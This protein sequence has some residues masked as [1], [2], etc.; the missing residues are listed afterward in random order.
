MSICVRTLQ[1]ISPN[2]C[3][4]SRFILP[5]FN[6]IFDI[7][8]LDAVSTYILALQTYANELSRVRRG[9]KARLHQLTAWLR[10]KTGSSVWICLRCSVK[11][12]SNKGIQFIVRNVIK[13]FSNGHVTLPSGLPNARGSRFRMGPNSDI[14]PRNSA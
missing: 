8:I 5:R 1:N 11:Y 6:V 2:R 14:R 7:Y 10:K 12:T 4:G 13:I 9:M 3:L